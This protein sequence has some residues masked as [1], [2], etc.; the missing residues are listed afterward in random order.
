MQGETKA[1][2]TLPEAKVAHETGHRT[3]AFRLI[4]GKADGSPTIGLS[5]RSVP[6]ILFFLLQVS[7][8]NARMACVS[9]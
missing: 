4:D 8:T 3:P 7:S 1:H 9:T 6:L 2:F 5:L